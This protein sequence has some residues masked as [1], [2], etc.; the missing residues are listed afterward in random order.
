MQRLDQLKQMKFRRNPVSK[1]N[2]TIAEKLYSLKDY[3]WKSANYKLELPTSLGLTPWGS[4]QCVKISTF[5]HSYNAYWYKNGRVNVEASSFK[6]LIDKIISSGID[7]YIL[8]FDVDDLNASLGQ[9][10]KI[11][12]EN[13]KKTKKDNDSK[14]VSKVMSRI[15]DKID[16]EDLNQEELTSY[17]YLEQN[18]LLNQQIIEYKVLSTKA[19]LICKELDIKPHEEKLNDSVY[20]TKFFKTFIL[21]VIVDYYKDKKEFEEQESKRRQQEFNERREK[22]EKGISS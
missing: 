9:Q 15:V 8:D 5:N 18:G 12:N 4:D 3:S 14:F 6:E 1:I 11:R 10:L 16:N 7:K 13:S 21:E 17:Q 2:E 19:N 22:Y 20:P